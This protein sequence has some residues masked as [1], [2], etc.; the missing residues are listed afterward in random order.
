MPAQ[1]AFYV[2]THR[3][4]FQAGVPAEILGVKMVMA[5]DGKTP[6]P[7]YHLRFPDGQE[8][9]AVMQDEDM[10][11]KAGLGTLYRII[12]E[13]QVNAGQIPPVVN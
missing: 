13:D 12:S 4:H 9:Y 1:K 6:R 5:P 10:V 3:Y 7:C 11:G 8:D 2:G